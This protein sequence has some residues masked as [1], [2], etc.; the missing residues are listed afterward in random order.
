M[1]LPAFGLEVWVEAIKDLLATLTVPRR[2][3][4][5]DRVRQ[6]RALQRA[7]RYAAGSSPYS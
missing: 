5:V 2:P 4:D 3:K 7:A 6:L 1:K